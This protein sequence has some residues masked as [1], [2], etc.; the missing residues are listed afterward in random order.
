[1]R[2]IAF[3]SPGVKNI[4]ADRMRLCQSR[5]SANSQNPLKGLVAISRVQLKSLE[6]ASALTA[7][8]VLAAYGGFQQPFAN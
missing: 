6:R 7:A 8:V 1:V 4:P 2:R 3:S 5:C